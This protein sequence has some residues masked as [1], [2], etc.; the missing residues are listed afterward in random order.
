MACLALAS[1]SDFV[2][3]LGSSQGCSFDIKPGED[4]VIV[5][6]K[7]NFDTC[8]SAEPLYQ[9]RGPVYIKALTPG[10]YYFTCSFAGHCVKGQ[11]VAIHFEP[12]SNV[13]PSAS[14]GPS[15]SSSASDESVA[16][17]HLQI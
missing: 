1:S 15:P 9:F 13:L 8:N 3:L 17:E 14:P 11:K 7:E 10:T 5:V 4:D 2:E 12:S 16:I 6:T